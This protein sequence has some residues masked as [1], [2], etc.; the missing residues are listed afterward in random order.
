MSAVP[1]LVA[2][3]WGSNAGV[4]SADPASLYVIALLQLA[5]AQDTG[6]RCATAAPPSSFDAL[7]V[8]SVYMARTSS[9]GASAGDAEPVA[10]TP[11]A[12]LA[13]CRARSKLD[14][15][16]D[17]AAQSR[18][19]ALQA[20]LDDVLSDVVLHSLFSLPSNFQALTAPSLAPPGRRFAL[21]SSLP[22][23]LRTAVRMRLQSERIGLWGVGGSWEREEAR[24]ARRWNS[25][26]GL[27]QAK[28]A[29]TLAPGV[30]GNTAH[31]DDVREQWERSHLASRARS[32]FRTVDAFLGDAR[33]F[34]G[35]DAPSS[36]DARL[37]SLLAPLLHA[38][39]S[40][41]MPL[42]RDLLSAEFPRLVQH[43]DRMRDTLWGGPA[44]APDHWAWMR[45]PDLLKPPSLL[46][47]LRRGTSWSPRSLWQRWFKAQSE[48]AKLPAT[49]R[50]GRL[51]WISTALVA[52]FVWLFVSGI[53]TIEYV[54]E[55]EMARAEQMGDEL[56]NEEEEE[57]T[58]GAE[59]AGQEA[60]LDVGDA[61]FDEDADDGLWDDDG[62][63]DEGVSDE[64]LDEEE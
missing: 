46:A 19:V 31:A 49:L 21:P 43:T 59:D 40:L 54:D 51:L 44:V 5:F 17:S 15:A 58:W 42:L 47:M 11:D 10:T 12:A 1:T 56:E 64:F 48:E 9:D 39:P 38:T 23:R 37:Y 26:A 45:D 3:A 50:L 4:P 53:V 41:P 35:C 63:L 29:R 18:A 34:F 6:V 2:S 61:E 20:L 24:E 25:R 62:G 57:P 13:F 33:F 55:D 7:P 28:E 32:L 36:S 60:A 52:P 14:A 30:V 22:R 8:P 27:E 16:L